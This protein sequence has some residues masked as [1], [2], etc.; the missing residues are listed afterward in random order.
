MFTGIITNFA[1]I[2]NIDLND[3]KD[4]LLEIELDKNLDRNFD[5]GC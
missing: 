4:C 2:K 3:N 5:L 1:R